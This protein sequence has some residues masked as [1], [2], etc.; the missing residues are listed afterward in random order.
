MNLN[1]TSMQIRQ[2]IP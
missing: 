2:L 1:V